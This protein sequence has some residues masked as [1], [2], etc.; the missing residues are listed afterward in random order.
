MSVDAFGWTPAIGRMRAFLIVAA[1]RAAAEGRIADN[2]A[3]LQE[4]RED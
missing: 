1:K 4:I 3:I 2:V